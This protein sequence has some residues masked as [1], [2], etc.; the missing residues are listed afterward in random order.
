MGSIRIQSLFNIICYTTLIGALILTVPYSR[1]AF[2]ADD[3]DLARQLFE[4]SLDSSTHDNRSRPIRGLASAKKENT[5]DHEED[6]SQIGIRKRATALPKK[7]KGLGEKKQPGTNSGGKP[8]SQIM[9]CIK[10]PKQT[11][12]PPS[13]AT[14]V[15]SEPMR[16]ML[17]FQDCELKRA[18]SYRAA[19]EYNSAVDALILSMPLLKQSVIVDGYASCGGVTQSLLSHGYNKLTS[20][21]RDEHTARHLYASVVARNRYSSVCV[22]PSAA[23]LGNV[24]GNVTDAEY[25]DA[26]VFHGGG[27]REVPEYDVCST[28]LKYLRGT[29][30][31]GVLYFGYVDSCAT[32]REMVSCVRF[33][34]AAQFVESYTVSR[35][36]FLYRNQY[37]AGNFWDMTMRYFTSPGVLIRRNRKLLGYKRLAHI[38]HRMAPKRAA[39]KKRFEMPSSEESQN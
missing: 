29:R 7:T 21:T 3:K 4:A 25:V 36:D 24:Y 30:P 37:P 5:I 16:P 11:E 18:S 22:V 31:G 34:E 14:V 12:E 32:L 19:A 8:R 28:L 17:S 23:D 13:A 20:I 15:R 33:G 38:L 2:D 6:L 26:F 1:G 9:N 27:M 39:H 35:E 10:P